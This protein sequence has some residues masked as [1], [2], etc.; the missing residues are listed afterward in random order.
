VY[1]DLIIALPDP[2]HIEY[3]DITEN[4]PDGMPTWYT[5]SDDSSGVIMEESL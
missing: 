5:V 2:F 4:H 1:F 3:F